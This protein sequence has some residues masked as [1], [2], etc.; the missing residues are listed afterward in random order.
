[1]YYDYDFSPANIEA[2]RKWLKNKYKTLSAL[3]REWE[4]DYKNWEE[5]I[6]ITADEAKEKKKNGNYAE[7]ADFRSFM[8]DTV[9]DFISFLQK[10]TE[11]I[12]P[13]AKWSIS[14]TQRPGAGDGL[15]WWKLCNT[16]KF[17]HSYNTANSAFMHQS[18][19]RF[20]GTLCSPYYS[21]YG[22]YGR[23]LEKTMWFCAFYETYG[24]SAWMTP[25]FFDSDFSLSVSG[26][27]QKKLMDEFKQ[28]SWEL[29]RLSNRERP[30]IA[31]HYSHPSIQAFFI[32]GKEFAIDAIR[33]GW[34]TM[35]H[36][37]GY[38]VDFVAYAQIEEPDF[39]IKQGYKVLILPQS[40]ALSEKEANEIEKFVKAGGIVIGDANIGLMN[41]HCRTLQE[42]YL[43]KSVF[44]IEAAKTIGP[45]P[46][47]LVLTKDFGE[48]KK[49]QSIQLSVVHEVVT[50]DASPVLMSSTGK[51]AIY[52]NNFGNG[53][54]I[55]VNLDLS[56]YVNQRNPKLAE[57]KKIYRNIFEGLFKDIGLHPTV[58]IKSA[59]NTPFEGHAF[60]Y[61]DGDSRYFGVIREFA[62]GAKQDKFKAILPEK[63][64]IYDV[65][66]HQYIG[67]SNTI[68]MELDAGEAKLYALSPVK[69]EPQE[70]ILTKSTYKQGEEVLFKIRNPQTRNCHSPFYVEVIDPESEIIPYYSNSC[71]I[72][73]NQKETEGSFRFGLNDKSGKWKIKV[74]DLFTG[75]IV[76]K[77]INLNAR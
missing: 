40:I 16:V 2:Y 77:E 49:D 4:T 56:A 60:W 13:M 37:M 62:S 74:T 64:H 52:I 22:S 17:L 8:D 59:E 6:P 61:T 50:K 70:I 33:N 3:N 30:K 14:G 68:D 10:T 1:V 53:K 26:R 39:L 72:K 7:W 25:C 28:G 5:I 12:D 75:S 38:Q 21:G 66:K 31:I 35:L 69:F 18:F 9:V 67:N 29:L 20:T 71:F 51:G 23:R 15:D 27:D 44:G 57:M 43:L 32:L 55:F 48:M 47:D 46:E 36:D 24:V 11:E 73:P 45:K 19:S 34:V 65:R 41:N 76:M 58:E 54:G 42:P 63:F